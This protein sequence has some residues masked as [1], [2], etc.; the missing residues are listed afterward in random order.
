MHA[1]GE[2]RFTRSSLLRR[3]GGIRSAIVAITAAICD[4]AARRN[5]IGTGADG[6]LPPIRTTGAASALTPVVTLGT[7]VA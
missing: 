5:A 3:A 4:V 1:M 2:C 7:E 6:S